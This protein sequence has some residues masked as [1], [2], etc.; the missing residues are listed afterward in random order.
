MSKTNIEKYNLQP[1]RTL[2]RKYEVIELLG[3]GWEGEVY[4]VRELSTGIERTAKLFFPQRN[5][6]NKSILFYAKKLHKLRHCPIVIHYN[7][8]EMIQVKGHNVNFLIS[9][10]V[11]GEL[12]SEFIKRQP[13]KRLTPFQGIHLLH[14]LAAGLECIHAMGEYHGDLHMGNII[15]QSFG[16]GFNLKL[17]DF[18]HWKAPSKENIRYDTVDMV[19]I[20]YDALGGQKYYSSQPK[21]IKSIINGLKHG[22]ILKKFNSAGKLR[23]FLEIMTW[24]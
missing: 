21:E 16:L 15:V 10:Y 13:G 8:Q 17:L 9:E 6:N 18:F 11:E 23:Q 1:G 22:L 14:A 7:A 4:L 20:L 3:S 5:H 19:R 24:E 12:L 2:A